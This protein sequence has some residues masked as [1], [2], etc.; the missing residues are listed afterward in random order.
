MLT[1]SFQAYIIHHPCSTPDVEIL[2]A[3]NNPLNNLLSVSAN[4]PLEMGYCSFNIV[5][6]KHFCQRPH[7][8]CEGLVCAGYWGCILTYLTPECKISRKIP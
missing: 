2:L 6:L 1:L 3:T 8:S 7:E 4:V 5:K